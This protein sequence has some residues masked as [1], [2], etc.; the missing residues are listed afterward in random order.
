M[1]PDIHDPPSWIGTIWVF[2]ILVFVFI[3]GL[4][5]RS[6]AGMRRGALTDA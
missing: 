1:W 2:L 6:G 3:I 5:A 4:K